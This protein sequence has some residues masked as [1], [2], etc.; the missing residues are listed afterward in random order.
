MAMLLFRLNGVPEDEAEAVRALLR[1]HQVDTHETH[2]GFWGIGLAAIWLTPNDRA[3]Y[4]RARE[5]ID[6]YQAEHAAQARAERD[7]NWRG[8]LPELV[9]QFRR[10]PLST[11]SFCLFTLAIVYF[12]VVPFFSL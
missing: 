12:A 7:A 3:E 5:L 4:L 9:D 6:A 10:K 2:R 8:H 1:T 11:V